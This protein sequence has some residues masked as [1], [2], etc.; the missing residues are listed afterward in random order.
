MFSPGENVH[1]SKLCT[2]EKSHCHIGRKNNSVISDDLY[3]K[4]K[5]IGISK[6]AQ[7]HRGGLHIPRN[8]TECTSNRIQTSAKY[9]NQSAE[10]VRPR[11]LASL[12][13]ELWN[14]QLSGFLITNPQSLPKK[15]DELQCVVDNNNGDV[16]ANTES[17][18]KRYN[19]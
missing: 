4:L 18:C 1:E 6:R 19:R 16:T 10:Q 8:I 7:G 13:E 3:S 11:V 14:P 15:L 12:P 5:D 9:H 17:W 2:L